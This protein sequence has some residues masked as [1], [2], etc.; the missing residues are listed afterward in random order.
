WLDASTAP[1]DRLAAAR[2]LVA[3]AR[4]LYPD[5]KNAWRTL[6]EALAGCGDRS[7]ADR[8][9]HGEVLQMVRCTPPVVASF[10]THLLRLDA[11]NPTPQRDDLAVLTVAARLGVH[12]LDLAIRRV[13]R[14][15]PS[16]ASP[17]AA[18]LRCGVRPSGSAALL[19]DAWQD[20][21]ALGALEDEPGATWLWFGGQ[22]PA[23]F[24]ELENE[25]RTSRSTPRRLRCVLALGCCPDASTLPVLLERLQSRHQGEAHAA[26]F[27]IAGLPRRCLQTLVAKAT[28][29][30]EQF[31]L[32]AALARAALPESRAW[33]DAMAL[34]PAQLRFLDSASLAQFP[35]VV[36]WFRE[37]LPAIGD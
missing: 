23:V 30:D 2:T 20:L 1:L 16:L 37:R 14:R 9:L 10:E 8:V 12:D 11:T 13:L 34:S 32:R 18:A 15:A 31:L 4:P 21:V 29:D 19:L 3:A 7:A 28:A 24:A 36:G 27:A 25:L 33:T 5:A 17:L 6:V 26:A 22:P 35:I